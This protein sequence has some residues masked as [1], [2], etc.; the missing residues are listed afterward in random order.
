[1][2]QGLA[3]MKVQLRLISAATLDGKQ[4]KLVVGV[5]QLARYSLMLCKR[6]ALTQQ[7][8]RASRVS[9]IACNPCT[10]HQRIADKV[11]ATSA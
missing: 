2:K 10:P 7:R 8:F 3:L 6:E 1:M 9:I 11:C 4:T 5:A